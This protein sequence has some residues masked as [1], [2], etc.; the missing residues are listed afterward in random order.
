VIDRSQSPSPS[1]SPMEF[2]E[3]YK[4]AGPCCFS[5]DSR[6]LAVAL[7]HRLFIRNVLSLKVPFPFPFPMNLLFHS[8]IKF[9]STEITNY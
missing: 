4:Q 9:S 7:D 3:A 1:P 5:P 2:T 6:F 8:I